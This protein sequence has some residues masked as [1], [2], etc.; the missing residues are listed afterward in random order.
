MGSSFTGIGREVRRG[1]LNSVRISKTIFISSSAT[2]INRGCSSI[3]I[4]NDLGSFASGVIA[5]LMSRIVFILP[6]NK[7]IPRDLLR[8][9]LGV[10]VASRI[11][12][13][14]LCSGRHNVGAVRG[15]NNCAIVAR[16]LG[17]T[18]DFRL[19]LGHLVSVINTLINLLVAKVLMVIVKPVVCFSSPKPVFFSRG[20]INRGKQVFGVCGFHDVCRSTRRHGGRLVTVG[21][22]GKF[23]FGT[24]GS[25]QVVNSNGSNS[26]R[27]VN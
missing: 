18:S 3:P 17:V 23:V 5:S 19:T 12:V 13:D 7:M 22:V 15:I 27:N 6:G 11:S 14:R 1:S 8:S 16:D 20:H 21:A 9:L 25:P 26:G 10:K 24:S 4:M 2:G